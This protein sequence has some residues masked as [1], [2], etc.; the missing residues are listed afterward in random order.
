MPKTARRPAPLG[1]EVAHYWLAQRMARATG[2]D[3]VGATADGKLTQEEWS[4]MVLRCRGCQWTN[5]CQSWL[6]D[7]SAEGE[8]APPVTCVNHKR[9]EAL[10]ATHQRDQE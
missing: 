2:T 6:E 3:L 4:E 10:H 1:D 5:G 7:L 9:F 8:R